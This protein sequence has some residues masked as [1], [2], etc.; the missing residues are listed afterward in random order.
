MKKRLHTT[1]IAFASPNFN[2]MYRGN[3]T[4]FAL[5]EKALCKYSESTN[6][7]HSDETITVEEFFARDDVL[8]IKTPKNILL[9]ETTT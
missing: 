4:L 2:E 7:A 8:F 9:P 1:K 3:S 5:S 6:A